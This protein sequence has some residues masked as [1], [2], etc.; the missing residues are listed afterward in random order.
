MI[1]FLIS[2]K[3]DIIFR[4]IVIFFDKETSGASQQPRVV[5]NK[6]YDDYEVLMSSCIKLIGLCYIRNLKINIVVSMWKL[7]QCGYSLDLGMKHYLI[8]HKKCQFL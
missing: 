3:N 8:S 7:M 6:N 2:N 1:L 4:I 5:L